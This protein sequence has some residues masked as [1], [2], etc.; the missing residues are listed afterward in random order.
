MDFIKTKKF[1]TFLSLLCAIGV[2][3]MSG[4]FQSMAYWGSDMTWY[5]VGVSFTYF[6]WL[7]G[8]VFLVL[9]ITKK[10]HM[11]GKLT[12]GLTIAQVT[13]VILLISGFLWTTFVII[14]G[15]SGM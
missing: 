11:K 8:I 14:A 4:P 5:W 10:E 3:L 1:Y 2:F 12:F 7:M 15:M 6:L 13:T 9:A